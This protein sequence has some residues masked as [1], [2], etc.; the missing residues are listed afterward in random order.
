MKRI[1]KAAIT[2]FFHNKKVWAE[3][4]EEIIY[5]EWSY[6]ISAL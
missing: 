5:F 4:N 6:L 1:V 2:D 3:T